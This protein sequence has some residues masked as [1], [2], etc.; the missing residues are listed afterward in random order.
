M[1]SIPQEWSNRI[2]QRISPKKQVEL[3]RDT[4]HFKLLEHGFICDGE[5]TPTEKNPSALSLL[6]LC[7]YYRVLNGT[8]LQMVDC[9]LNRLDGT[10]GT[11]KMY[12]SIGGSIRIQIYSLV[13][14]IPMHEP[15]FCWGY[16]QTQQALTE[17]RFPDMPYDFS[18]SFIN[19]FCDDFKFAIDL[20]QEL[21]FEQTIPWLNEHS[22]VEQ[23]ADWRMAKLKASPSNRYRNATFAIWSQLQTRKW[24]NAEVCIEQCLAH[25]LNLPGKHSYRNSERIAQWHTIQQLILQ[26]D[27]YLIDKLLQDNRA[28]NVRNLLIAAPRLGN[29]L[30]DI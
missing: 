10:E 30:L 5:T 1:R 17:F 2:P 20:E 9:F 14:R 27:V 25:L 4:F 18:T 28:S 23:Y 6:H 11:Y 3:F 12:L 22:T 15:M 8:M 26:R 16:G 21:F 19:A 24:E 29:C 13:D 7:R